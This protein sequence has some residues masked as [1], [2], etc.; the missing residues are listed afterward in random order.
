MLMGDKC[1][2]W[3]YETHK[4][5]RRVLEGSHATHAYSGMCKLLLCG[6]CI[7]L[8]WPLGPTHGFGTSAQTGK[9][10][11]CAHQKIPA[12]S[13][14]SSTARQTAATLHFT[15]LRQDCSGRQQ[16]L[17]LKTLLCLKSWTFWSPEL[18]GKGKKKHWN[19][20]V[21]ILFWQCSSGIHHI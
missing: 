9:T 4:V 14:S 2:T 5:R 17:L 1:C 7:K 8:N 21:S 10:F 12:C 15:L 18:L 11:L 13:C 20:S 19:N 3:T 16:A 6:P